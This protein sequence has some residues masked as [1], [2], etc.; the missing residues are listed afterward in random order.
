M[1][2]MAEKLRFGD[3]E[4]D[5]A[6]RQLRRDGEEVELGSRYFDA[7]V[8]LVSEAGV[9]VPKDRFMDEVWRGI[10]V[11]D[12]ALTQC[13]RSLR[14]AL[15]DGAS[16]P[17]YIQTV[18]KH[19]YRFIAIPTTAVNTP[20][21]PAASLRLPGAVAGAATL[22]GGVAGALGGLFY[23]VV[24]GTGGI[25][26]VLAL[27]ALVAALGVLAGAGVGIGMASTLAL[28][29]RADGVLVFGGAIGGMAV[30]ALGGTLGR[31]GIALIT[32]RMLG[33]VTG[34][35]EGLLLGAASGAVCLLVLRQR[36]KMPALSALATMIVG[37]M[38]GFI[39]H[40]M[41]GKLLGGTLY[42]L[43]QDLGGTRLSLGRIGMLTGED[44]F[45]RTANLVTSVSEAAV[46]I[47]AIAI[48]VFAVR[49]K[50]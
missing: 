25:A 34:I 20:H 24:A 2:D 46:F 36:G 35:F 27:T 49:G 6:N 30:G 4:L 22:A 3:F 19:G 8:L 14:R 33:P 28:R 11:T 32:D 47:L 16:A 26:T 17:R 18:P 23:G 7:L 41:G 12:E 5:L 31:D 44:S 9:L 15:G 37:G 29:A 39:I 1:R 40:I 21:A 42:I 48:G 38:A 50:S 45:G 43:E 13:I 10:P